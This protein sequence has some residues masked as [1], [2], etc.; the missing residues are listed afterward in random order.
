MK[1]INT[2]NKKI[3]LLTKKQ[4]GSC[5]NAKIQHICKEKRVNKYLRDRKYRKV[6][7][8]YHYTGEYRGAAHICNLKYINEDIFS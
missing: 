1:I 5:E 7:D 6:S 3:K 8:H 4:Q 2:K